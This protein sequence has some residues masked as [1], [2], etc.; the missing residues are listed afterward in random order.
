MPKLEIEHL[1]QKLQ[2]RTKQLENG[3]LL[4][5][6]DINVLLNAKQLNDLKNNWSKQQALRKTH[7]TPITEQD[8]KRIGWKT[9]REVRLDI[10]N[11]ALVDANDSLLGSFEKRLKA[12]EVKRDKIYMKEINKNIKDGVDKTTA[13]L[14][15][16]NELSRHG[17][18]KIDRM[19]N[20][21]LGFSKRDREMR[22]ME[23]DLRERFKLED[24]KKW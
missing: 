12:L 9:I 24:K 23:D 16:N 15:A 22:E 7:K 13:A 6:R 1:I 8:K 18:Q 3:K 17:L 21:K 19:R 10:L 20:N 11:K 4:E 2:K 5:A 14:R